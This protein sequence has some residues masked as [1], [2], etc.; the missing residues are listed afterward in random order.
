MSGLVCNLD[1][2][3]L[4]V[5]GNDVIL[6]DRIRELG[7]SI[8]KWTTILGLEIDCTGYTKKNFDKIWDKIKAITATW[9]PFKLSLTGRI[10]IAKSLLYSQINYLGC[11]LLF[12]PEVINAIDNSITTFV[13]GKLNVAKKRLHI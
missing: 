5:L 7:F 2:T 8:V 6:D 9:A 11:F 13:K 4:T 12:P 1:K 3:T 10:N